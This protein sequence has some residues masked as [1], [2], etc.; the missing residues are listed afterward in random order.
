[1][2]MIDCTKQVAYQAKRK[3]HGVGYNSGGKHKI[4]ENNKKTELYSLWA[5][6]IQRCYSDK[7][8]SRHPTYI[9][10]TVCEEWLDF[11]NF[12]EWY[13]SHRFYGMGYH[14][15]KDLLI[16]GN[17]IYSAETC[18]LVPRIINNLLVDSRSSR[19]NL[20]QGV[21]FDKYSKKYKSQMNIN[22]KIV[23]LGRYTDPNEAS[24]AYVAHKERHVKNKALEWA[25]RIEWRV[26]KNLMLWSVDKAKYV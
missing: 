5:A 24:K 14:L 8:Q 6:M 4:R 25:N 13:T 18:T 11:Q 15:D 1:M 7:F 16:E 20:P 12:A 23:N 9:G 21:Y 2:N 10:C 26:F 17:K 22:G 19:G 3:V